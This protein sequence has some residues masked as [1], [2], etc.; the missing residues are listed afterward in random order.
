MRRLMILA[1]VANLLLMLVS[2]IML[3]DQVAIHFRGGGI[4]DAWA[5]KWVNATIFTLMQI[6]FFVLCLWIGRLTV[7]MPAEWVSLPNKAHWLKP[8]NRVE[9][10]TR[11]SLLMEEFGFVL[12]AFMFIV[13]LLTLDANLSEPVQLN[14]RLFLIFFAIYMM[15]VPYWLVKLFRRLKASG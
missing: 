9:L 5:S 6:P 8:Q 7:S 1:L 4:P 10:Q 12:F 14:E 2:L 3:P 15:Y 13:G 11:I